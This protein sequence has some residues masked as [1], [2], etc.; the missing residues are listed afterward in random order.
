MNPA[1]RDYEMHVDHQVTLRQSLSPWCF[2]SCSKLFLFFV[3][4][5]TKEDKRLNY[6][7]YASTTE[8]GFSSLGMAELGEVRPSVCFP[9]VTNS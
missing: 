6:L 2:K 1:R 4:S 8:L 7:N 5:R 9:N 3:N